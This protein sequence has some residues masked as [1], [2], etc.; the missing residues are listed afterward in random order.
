MALKPRML[1]MS[2]AVFDAPPPSPAWS[3]MPGTL[4]SASLS[5]V[6]PC[7]LHRRA[8]DHCDRLRHFAERRR[9]LGRRDRWS[10]TTGDRN[11]LRRPYVHGYEVASGEH[12]TDA[13]ADEQ[14]FQRLLRSHHA[15]DTRR[16][17]ILDGFVGEHHA[18]AGH[19]T[20]LISPRL[21]IDPAGISKRGRLGGL[22]LI[23]AADRARRRSPR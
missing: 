3:V 4:R 11:E 18:N 7:C 6:T 9:V 1:N 12:V 13:R 21:P 20:E 19:R 17:Q 16:W 14:P 2:P 23:D 22:P 15:G 10:L 5:V 8:R